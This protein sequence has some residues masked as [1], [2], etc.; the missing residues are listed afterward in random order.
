MSNNK[1]FNEVVQIS[2]EEFP[3]LNELKEIFYKED[4]NMVLN[5][6]KNRMI[7]AKRMNTNFARMTI[8]DFSMIPE[9][10]VSDVKDCLKKYGYTIVDIEDNVNVVI[11]WKISF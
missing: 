8:Q 9:K 1:I 6:V 4:F 3:S 7:Q 11:G 2:R 10:V 5:T